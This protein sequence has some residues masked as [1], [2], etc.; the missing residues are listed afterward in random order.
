MARGFVTALVT[1]VMGGLYSVKLSFGT[2]HIEGCAIWE[3][4]TTDEIAPKSLGARPGGGSMLVKPYSH[5][6]F[7]KSMNALLNSWG[8]S[9]I[10]KCPA[11]GIQTFFA[12]G[13]GPRKYLISCGL[14]I[15]S[16]PP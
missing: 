16:R 12:P 13:I 15:T 1:I 11:L 3:K 8:V 9:H 10:T 7:M 6:M 4:G 14:T 2:T 5:Y